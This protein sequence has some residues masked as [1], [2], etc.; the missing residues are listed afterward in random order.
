M[1][2]IL[3][4]ALLTVL[5]MPNLHAQKDPNQMTD[6]KM[7]DL[8]AGLKKEAT[9]GWTKGGDLGLNLAGSANRNR[10]LSDG[11]N[12][13]GFGGIVNLFAN[14]K[15]AKSFFDNA[16]MMQLA[17]LRNGG[18]GKDFLKNGDILRFNST[19]GYAIKADK[20]FAAVDGRIETQLLPT[21]DGGLLSAPNS[22]VKRLSEFLA[23]VSL[24]IAPGLV[25]KPDTHW[26]FFAS[27]AAVDFIYVGNEELARQVG[28]PLGNEPGKNSRL[29]LGPAL[30]AKYNNTFLN[31]R[32]AFNSSMG[33]NSSYL[34]A[35]NGRILWTN[36]ANIQIYKGLSLKLVGEAF[37]D[38][39]TKAIITES[40]TGTNPDFGL[41]TTW[42][43]A[44]FLAYA[45]IF[46]PK[47]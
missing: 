28:A 32:I 14:K 31:E 8:S 11:V 23:P 44:F 22:S 30:R 18:Q 7:D 10:R 34:D 42:R 6:K 37:Y 45:R 5:C 40:P 16:F 27:P 1:K 9:M 29:L 35:L 15:Q 26:S 47:K 43:G 3:F 24:L 46:G 33:W 25:Y 13:L 38:H 41:A 19:W 20:L 12:Q 36:Q 17:A 39:Y 4:F 2:K 21:F